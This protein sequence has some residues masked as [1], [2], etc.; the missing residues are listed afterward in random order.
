MAQNAHL[1][2]CK[3]R[4]FTISRLVL[5]SLATFFKA[6]LIFTGLVYMLVYISICIAGKS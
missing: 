1:L 2:K 5:P 6:R 3:F 4:F